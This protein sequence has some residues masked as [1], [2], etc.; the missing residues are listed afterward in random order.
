YLRV[1]PTALSGLPCGSRNKYSF[2]LEAISSGE[3]GAC[4]RS[5]SPTCSITT[6]D[7]CTNQSSPDGSVVGVFA[8]AGTVCQP[9][10]SAPCDELVHTDQVTQAGPIGATL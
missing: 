4:C 1:R 8:G 9:D 2:K 7:A 10:H 6:R 5:L 3:Y